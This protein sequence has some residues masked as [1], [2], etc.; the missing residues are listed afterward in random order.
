MHIGKIGHGSEL[1]AV[2]RC[3]RTGD[4]HANRNAHKVLIAL[5]DLKALLGGEILGFNAQI[6]QAD[7]GGTSEMF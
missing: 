1:P 5:A 4:G 6:V 2:V 3:H 7:V